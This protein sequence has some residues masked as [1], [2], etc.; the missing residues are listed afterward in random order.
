MKIRRYPERILVYEALGF[1]AILAMVLMDEIYEMPKRLFAKYTSQPEMW[2]GSFEVITVILV[3]VVILLA[4]NRLVLRLFR[5]EGFLK[6]CAWCRKIQYEGEWTSVEK[7][8]SSGF[9]TQTTH[10]MCPDCFEKSK[11]SNPLRAV[12]RHSRRRASH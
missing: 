6:V 9:D 4:T 3:A 12:R 5:L 10:G 7:I 8:F 2:E 1:L 11:G